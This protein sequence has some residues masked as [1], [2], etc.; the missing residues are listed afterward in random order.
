[1]KILFLF[2]SVLSAVLLSVLSVVYAMGNL[3]FERK[4]DLVSEKKEEAD[5]ASDVEETLSVFPSQRRTVD[6]LIERLGHER[7][8]Y[9][10]KVELLASREVE[11]EHRRKI[12]ADMKTE[13]EGMQT[14]LDANVITIADS[15]KDNFKRLANVYSK[16]DPSGAATL[17]QKLESERA[18]KILNMI[19]ERSA[20]AILDAAIGEGADGVLAAVKWSDSIRKIRKESKKKG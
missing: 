17:L 8:E 5:V 7:K 2:V 4:A 1:M 18:A 20:A 3:S 14:K 12:M 11:M 16:M 10:K 9:Q 6:D 15:E 19:G 13:L